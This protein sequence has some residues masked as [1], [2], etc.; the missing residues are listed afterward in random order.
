[1]LYDR[2]NWIFKDTVMNDKA[3]QLMLSSL[4]IKFL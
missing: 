4:I 2:V 3:V 1:M